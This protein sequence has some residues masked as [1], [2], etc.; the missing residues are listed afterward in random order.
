MEIMRGRNTADWRCQKN[1]RVKDKRVD[2]SKA[3]Y[4]Q[5]QAH[6]TFARQ[7]HIKDPSPERSS[8]EQTNTRM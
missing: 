5:S 4:I 3:L 7:E 1:K 8:K 2:D 6:S